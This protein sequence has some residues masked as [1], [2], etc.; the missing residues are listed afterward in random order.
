MLILNRNTNEDPNNFAL[1]SQI[2]QNKNQNYKIEALI[3]TKNKSKILPI[4]DKKKN[5]GQKVD[6]VEWVDSTEIKNDSK[7][8][9][10]TL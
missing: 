9:Q 8:N 10:S 4:I 1:S 2:N 3:E 6:N 5:Q 7:I